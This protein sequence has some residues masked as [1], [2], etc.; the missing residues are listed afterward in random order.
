MQVAEEAPDPTKVSVSNLE[1]TSDQPNAAGFPKEVLEG[2]RK[3]IES[4]FQRNRRYLPM[5]Y[6]KMQMCR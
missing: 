5:R 3:Y 1:T 2:H 6:S 4:L